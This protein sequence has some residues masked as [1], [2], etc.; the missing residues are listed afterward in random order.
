MPPDPRLTAL[1][2][3]LRRIAAERGAGVPW[4]DV[5]ALWG[6]SGGTVWNLAHGREPVEWETRRRFGLPPAPNHQTQILT[7]RVC[8]TENCGRTFVPNCGTRLY[9]FRC[10]PTRGRERR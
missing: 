2:V 6:V 9:C 8:A 3:V 4:A 5:G 7:V 10:A 1:D